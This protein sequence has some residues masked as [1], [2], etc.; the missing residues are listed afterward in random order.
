MIVSISYA[1]NKVARNPTNH[2]RVFQA[3]RTP[4]SNFR[5]IRHWGWHRM[6]TEHQRPILPWPKASALHFQMLETHT[7]GGKIMVY[8]LPCFQP[9][10]RP[11]VQ[12]KEIWN[13]QA[14]VK[15]HLHRRRLRSNIGIGVVDVLRKG[16]LGSCNSRSVRPTSWNVAPA[17]QSESQFQGFTAWRV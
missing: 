5:K 15:I 6:I 9:I 11:S 3:V 1:P 7:C 12:S 16:S 4:I 2:W 14:K 8:F 13:R 17:F 10:F